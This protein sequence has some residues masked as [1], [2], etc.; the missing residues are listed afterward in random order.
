[1]IRDLEHRKLR[2]ADGTEIAYQIRG[3]GPAVVFANGLGGT[4]LAFRHLWDAL[5]TEH[6]IVS[7]DYRGLYDSAVPADRE[8]L[9]MWGHAADLVA[10]L[11]HEGIDRAVVVGWSMGVQVAFETCRRAA[12][13]VSGIVAING[14]AGR[15]WDTV[16]SSRASRHVL[17]LLIRA[18]RQQSKIVGQATRVAIMTSWAVPLMQRVGLVS[19]NLD[20]ETFRAIAAGFADMDWGIYMQLLELLGEHDATDVLAGLDIPVLVITGDRD[21]MTPPVCAEQIHRA[22]ARSKVVVIRG[23][24]HYTPLEFPE[25]VCSEVKAFMRNVE[26]HRLP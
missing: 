14:T 3:D 4:Y 17:P 22:V 20:M 2:A 24:T 25:I 13:R 11:D 7:W 6:T 15:P 21:I 1:M 8:T 18:A 5:G 23:G 10:L 26:A 9:A 12:E 19:H 16:L